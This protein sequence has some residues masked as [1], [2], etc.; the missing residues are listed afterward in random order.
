MVD[1][2]YSKH[3]QYA[4][5][6]IL[7]LI[8]EAD[9][10]IDPNEVEFMN[11]V[12]RDFSITEGEMELINQY[13]LSSSSSIIKALPSKEKEYAI[14]LFIEMAKCDGYADPRE[15]NIIEGLAND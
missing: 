7:I 14:K 4:I 8:M 6:S 1:I 2:R 10:I 3:Q 13:D 12:Y 5:I 11:N 15:L 9:G